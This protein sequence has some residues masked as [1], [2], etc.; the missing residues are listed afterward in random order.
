MDFANLNVAL[1][2]RSVPFTVT[3]KGSTLRYT[4]NELTGHE[5][6]LY[7]AQMIKMGDLVEKLDPAGYEHQQAHLIHRCV[8]DEK[9][10][11]I[12]LEE[13][14]KWPVPAQEAVYKACEAFNGFDKKSRDAEKKESSETSS[15]GTE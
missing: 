11:Q 1:D 3:L 4:M 2:L 9:G 6:D 12:P 13:I 15:S 8:R 10:Q 5:R 7:M 14:G